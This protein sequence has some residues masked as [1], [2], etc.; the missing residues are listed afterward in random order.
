MATVDPPRTPNVPPEV[1]P[2]RAR[3]FRIPKTFSALRHRNFQLF[4][5][6]Q[7]IS[8]MGSWMQIIGQGW[9]VYEISRSEQAL[10]IVGFASAIPALAITP[11][12]GVV[13][14]RVS[15]RKVMVLTQ[16]GAM[17]LAF[18]LAGLT[19]A[20]VVQVWHV[21]MLAALLGVVNAF[22]GPARQAFVVD[23]V[24]R[25]DL[26]NAIAI[27]SM[28]FNGARII[29]PAI[30]GLLLVTF[31]AAW[32]FLLNGITFSATIVGLLLMQLPPH[33]S[34]PKRASTWEQLRGG[35]QYVAEDPIMRALLLLALIFSM[36]GVSYSTVLPAFVDKAL[37]QGADAFGAVNAVLG[38]GAVAGA[39]LVA[40]YGDQ[41]VRGRWLIATILGFPILLAIFAMNR[42]Y[43]V[44]LGLSI[45]LGIGF[46]QTFTLL[47]TLLQT[48][49]ADEMRGRVLSLYTLTFFGFMPFGNLAIGWLAERWE[50]SAAI[51]VSAL[52]SFTLALI[53]IWKTP[54]LRELP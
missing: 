24:G 45:F 43:P 6:G 38:I 10:G 3:Q 48:Q 42:S 41:G 14:D 33:E 35:V 54:T 52:L 29:G 30:G 46:M 21:V 13:L 1:L 27:N 8:L 47:N 17:S 25:E 36:F 4:V 39:L 49:L 31:G 7:L 15:R 20:G 37:Q 32:C 40:R 9:L 23:M 16:L 18:A 53:V 26:P 2:L 51:L 28:T 5:G 22:D 19:F 11:W 12:A 50:L 34:K 44:T